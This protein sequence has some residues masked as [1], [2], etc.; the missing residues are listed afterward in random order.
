MGVAILSGLMVWPLTVNVPVK[1]R[2]NGITFNVP[3]NGMVLTL[4]V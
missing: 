3:V 2:Y 4:E 1:G